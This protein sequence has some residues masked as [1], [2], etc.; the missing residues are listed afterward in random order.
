MRVSRHSRT[1]R[2]PGRQAVLLLGVTLLSVSGCVYPYERPYGDRSFGPNPEN[3]GTPDEPRSCSGY[4][5]ARP[6]YGYTEPTPYA[7]PQ[8]PY[9]Q[10]AYPQSQYPQS[11]YPQAQT[12][13]SRYPQTQY[14]QTQYPP[15]AYPQSQYPQGQYPQSQYAQPPNAPAPY[16]E[17]TPLAPPDAYGRGSY[18]P[19]PT[20]L[21]P[22]YNPYAPPADRSYDGPANDR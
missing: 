22:D 10:P 14:P 7:P 13:Q 5:A 20:P 9:P 6:G 12:P 18:V 21:R 19:P 16:G 1:H 4:E 17:A 15:P 11:Q 8:V 2:V 3:C